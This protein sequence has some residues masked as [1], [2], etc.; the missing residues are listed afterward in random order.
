MNWIYLLPLL[1]ACAPESL[2]AVTPRR[3]ATPDHADAAT[4]HAD[5]ADERLRNTTDQAAHIQDILDEPVHMQDE[6]TYIRWQNDP[7]RD[8]QGDARFEQ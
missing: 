3:A 7:Q 5:D 2:Q 6:P 8:A 1:V 4:N